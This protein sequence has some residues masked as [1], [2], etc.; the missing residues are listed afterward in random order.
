MHTEG[1]DMGK[2]SV[3]NTPP[4]NQTGKYDP[5]HPGY[6]LTDVNVRGIATFLIGLL[7]TVV[8]FFFVCYA[9]GILINNGLKKYDGASNKWTVA[10]GEAPAGK[11]EDLKSN[12]SMEQEELGQ[13]TNNFPAPRLEADDGEQSTADLHAREDLML[14]HYSLVDGQPGTIRIPIERAMELVAERGLPLN[15]SSAAPDNVAHAGPPQVQVPLTDGFARTGFEQTQI[16][17]REQQMKMGVSEQ[18]T[19]A[20]LTPQK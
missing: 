19:H 16:E 9:M 8:V 12:A 18:A 6:E 4:A 1:H 2:D 7:G 11:G 3:G 14:E 20:E 13:M 10:R 15:Q 17:A 5:E